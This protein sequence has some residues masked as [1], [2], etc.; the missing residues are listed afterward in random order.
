MRRFVL[1]LVLAVV[2]VGRVVADE[3]SEA[4]ALCVASEA[5]GYDATRSGSLA[6]VWD[7]NALCAT[8]S[9][10]NAPSFY[11]VASTTGR[12]FV[13]VAGD[14]AITPILAY[15]EEYPAPDMLSMHPSLNGWFRYV[16]RS[17]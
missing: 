10:N 4:T 8:R 1:L 2:S 11:V 9:G 6:I 7:S 13:I 12:G 14:D 15:S 3:V 17:V 5:L 16:D